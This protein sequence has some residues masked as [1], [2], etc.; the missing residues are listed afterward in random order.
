MMARVKGQRKPIKHQAAA[1]AAFG[2]GQ[3]G[4]L[5][6]SDEFSEKINGRHQNTP[7]SVFKITKSMFEYI[8]SLVEEDMMEKPPHL[9][10]TNGQPVSL[11]DQVAVALRRLGSG[12][13][14][15][16]IGGIFGVSNTMVS[17][18]TWK[19]VESMENRG[20]LHLKWPPTERELIEIKSK[21]GKLQSLPN[22][23]GVVDV[24]HINMCLASTEPNKDVWLDHENKHSMVLQAIVDPDMR[25]RDI[26]TGWPGQMKDWMVFEDSTFHKLCDEGERL[27]G[28]I[29]RLPDGS[30]IREYIIGDSGYPLLPY[31]IVPYKG[32]EQELSVSQA[33][34]N[35]RHLETRMVAKRALVMLKEMWGIIQGTMWRPNKHRLSKVILVCCILHNIV[36]D[37]GDRVQNEQLSNLPTN[38]DPGYHQ[39][40]CEAED[41]QGVLLRENV[42]RYLSQ[43]MAP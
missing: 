19:F 18:I 37:M 24:T 21:F 22:C 14:L 28:N 3:E 5:D 17:Q 38:H 35:R 2:W 41:P 42:S 15:V 32:E 1:S 43:G 11:H 4:P 7:T 8:C 6:W 26:V 30:E 36:I 16:L 34:F 9:A 27:N 25:F 10:F 33:N 20:L 40:I 39:L 29:I 31:L 13:S 23:C 12:D